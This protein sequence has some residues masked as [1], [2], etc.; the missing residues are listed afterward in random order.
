MTVR[1]KPL[2]I[3][4]GCFMVVGLMGLMAMALVYELAR[5]RRDPS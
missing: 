5:D 4:S 2:M 1:W 3:L